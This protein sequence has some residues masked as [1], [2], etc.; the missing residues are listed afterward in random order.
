MAGPIYKIWMVKPTEAYYQLSEE[1][2]NNFNA[3]HQA[4]LEK[5]G[6]KSIIM[7]LG[8]WST[9][10]WGLFG[11]EEFPDI[12]AV[13]KHTALQVEGDHFR[14]TDSFSMLGTEW[15]PA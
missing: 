15:P 14:Y 5:V 7:C 9:N 8:A 13:Q 10:Q 2:R 6:A 4:N 12:E 11:V 1:E 3:T